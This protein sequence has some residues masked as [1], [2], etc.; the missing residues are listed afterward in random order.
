M[1]TF[2]RHLSRCFIAGIVALLPV[3]GLVLTVAYLEYTI[4]ESGLSAQPWYFPGLGLLLAVVIVYV[5]GLIVTTVMGRWAWSL[6]EGLIRRLPGLGQLYTTMKQVLGYGEGEGALFQR[7]VLISDRTDN[8]REMGFVTQ[9]RDCPE[10][11]GG[12]RLNVFVPGS[13]NPMVGRLVVLDADQVQPT[14][15][16]V[17]D[18]M[19]ALVAVGAA[20]LVIEAS[21]A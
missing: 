14:D 17:S 10:A 20:P 8:G 1:K 3:G 16:A 2:M 9:T 18:A 21:G 6:I 5:I 12:A 11:G 13:P 4:S 7:V 15:I 19:K